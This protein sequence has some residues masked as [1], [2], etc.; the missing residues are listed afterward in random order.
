MAGIKDPKG[1][2]DQLINWLNLES[3]KH[4]RIGSHENRVISGGEAKRTSIATEM[5]TDPSVIFLDEPT[6]GLDSKTALDVAEIVKMLAKN[7][8]TVITTIHQPS[9]ELLMKFDKVICMCRGEI[10]YYGSPENINV[11]FSQLGFEAPRNT[12]PAEHLM[13]ILNEDDIK[14]KA[15][16]EGKLLSNSEVNA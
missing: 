1:S 9:N 13:T 8:R 4:N 7:G 6:T 3:C 2:V 14:I 5:L 16:N 11:H 15:F 10:V 12:N